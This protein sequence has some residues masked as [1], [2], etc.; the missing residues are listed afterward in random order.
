MWINTWISELE[1]ETQNLEVYGWHLQ[2]GFYTHHC[3]SSA[4]ITFYLFDLL[5]NIYRIHTSPPNNEAKRSVYWKCLVNCKMLLLL[6]EAD[7]IWWR[8]GWGKVSLRTRGNCLH[9]L[10]IIEPQKKESANSNYYRLWI[11]VQSGQKYYFLFTCHLT[12]TKNFTEHYV[13]E[14][15]NN[16][17]RKQLLTPH[18]TE[19]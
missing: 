19:K 15:H 7:D 1:I 9:A 12:F 3:P 10:R 14:R 17:V 11:V 8:W 2:S 16:A 6:E 5:K 13:F 18:F 4:H